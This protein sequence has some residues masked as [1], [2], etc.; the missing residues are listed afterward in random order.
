MGNSTAVV[1]SLFFAG[2]LWL[3]GVFHFKTPEGTIVIKQMPA[4]AE[5]FVDGKKFEVRWNQGNEVA[6]VSVAPG[7]RQVRVANGNKTLTGQT[8][9]IHDNERHALRIALE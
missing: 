4:D 1:A 5:V 2:L 6:E 3:S 7:K 9:T 8:V